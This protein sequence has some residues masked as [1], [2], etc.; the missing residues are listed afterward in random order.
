[1][2][3]SISICISLSVYV[4]IHIYIY[5]CI[6][7]LGYVTLRD[8]GGMGARAGSADGPSTDMYIYIYIYMYMYT[9]THIVKQITN[10]Q[11]T[12]NTDTHSE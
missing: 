11:Q 1:M 7:S 5:I 12:N 3:I 10:K 2:Y 6:R 9:D 4:Y 8:V